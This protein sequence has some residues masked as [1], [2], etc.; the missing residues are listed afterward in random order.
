MGAILRKEPPSEFDH[1]LRM[2]SVFFLS[3]ASAR[4]LRMW[5]GSGDLNGLHSAGGSDRNV[6]NGWRCT[7]QGAAALAAL[8]ELARL[9]RAPETALA[10]AV[11]HEP[12]AA[13]RAGAADDTM[14]EFSLPPCRG[15]LPS[16]L[17]RF[18][19]GPSARQ[20]TSSKRS[21]WAVDLIILTRIR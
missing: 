20:R 3:S 9:A 8:L 10:Q 5:S 17:E 12:P 15:R 19:R 16:R 21:P 14:D 1:A 4:S 11:L 6:R 7:T 18:I 2:P 13:D